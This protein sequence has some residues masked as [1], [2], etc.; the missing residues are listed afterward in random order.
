MANKVR[1]G[2][3]NAHYSVVT[4]NGTTPSFATPVALPGAV[5]LSLEPQGDS[6]DFYADDGDYFS[7]YANNGYE[8]TLELAMIP[9]SFLTDCLGQTTDTDNLVV[10][11]SNDQPAYFAL[12]FEFTGDEKG[13]RHCMY[14]CTAS[15][16]TQAGDTKGESLEV[17]TEELSFKAIPIPG[18]NTIKAKSTPTT[19]TTRYNS[20]FTTVAL[21]DFPELTVSPASATFDGSS[22]VVLTVTGGT[23]DAIKLGGTAVAASN[24]TVSGGTVTLKHEYLSTLSAGVKRFKLFAGTNNAV[25]QVTI[26]AAS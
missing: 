16:P 9:D 13:I 25:V 5:S 6:S 17:K 3:K 20:W 24:Y 19:D 8:G 23:V 26:P 21:P 11:T 15:R 14:Y 22:D 2:L 18:T 12:L 7:R 10:E 4:M 1:F